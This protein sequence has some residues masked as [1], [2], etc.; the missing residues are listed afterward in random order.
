MEKLPEVNSL[1]NAVQEVVKNNKSIGYNPT[2]FMQIVTVNDKELINVCTSLVKSQDALSAIFDA[3]LKYP[4]LL[5]LEDL[6][7]V[8]GDQW[9]FDTEII[10]EAKLRSN[11]YDEII[12]R[13]RFTKS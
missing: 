12:G 7:G 8:Y 9:G 6:V 13:K 2:R 10:E 1:R 5:T 3:L 11:A 4:N